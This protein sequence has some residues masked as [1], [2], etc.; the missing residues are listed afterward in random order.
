MAE[1]FIEKAKRLYSVIAD[2]MYNYS[3]V[4]YTDARTKVEITCNFH[5]I[6]FNQSPHQ[7]YKGFGCSTC[8]KQHKNGFIWDDRTHK[9]HDSSDFIQ[10]NHTKKDD[11]VERIKQLL[12]S[13]KTLAPHRAD[14]R[15]R[16]CCDLSFRPGNDEWGGGVLAG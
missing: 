5:D 2:D 6:T 13:I 11:K 12:D 10:T 7:H 15:G 8:M 4:I 3:K 16:R 9:K 1:L 14:R